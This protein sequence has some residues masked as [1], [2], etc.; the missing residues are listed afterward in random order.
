M[1]NFLPDTSHYGKP[2]KLWFAE[3]EREAH[4]KLVKSISPHCFVIEMG[5]EQLQFE[6]DSAD[7]FIIEPDG[8]LTLWNCWS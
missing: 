6:V 3:T 7:D 5:N 8:S 1:K 4:G 2:I